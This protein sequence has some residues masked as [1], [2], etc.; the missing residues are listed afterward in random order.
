MADMMWLL[1]RL[2]AM[3]VPEVCW[4]LTQKVVQKMKK[5]ALGL[6]SQL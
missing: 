4:R 5:D 2:K 6:L 3:S 1:Q